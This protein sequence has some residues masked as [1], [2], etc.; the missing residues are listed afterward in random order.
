MAERSQLFDHQQ[1][2][3]GHSISSL[4]SFF[5]STDIG[6]WLKNAPS[7]HYVQDGLQ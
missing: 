7:L 1:P 2:F 4:S 3:Q 5:T 6:G